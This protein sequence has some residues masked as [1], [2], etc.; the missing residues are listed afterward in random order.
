M[1]LVSETT[2]RNVAICPYQLVLMARKEI[3]V[4]FI[5]SLHFLIIVLFQKYLREL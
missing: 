1:Q 2:S 4:A 5:S 3:V